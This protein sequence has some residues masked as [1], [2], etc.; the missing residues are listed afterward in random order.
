M[1]SAEA[2]E[3]DGTNIKAMF[4]CECFEIPLF[5]QNFCKSNDRIVFCNI[6]ENS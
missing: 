4:R 2:V 6:R 3:L 5:L 1:D